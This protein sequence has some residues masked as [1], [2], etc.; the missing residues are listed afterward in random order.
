MSERYALLPGKDAIGAIN[1]RAQELYGV[2]ATATSIIDSMHSD[3]I[4][5]EMHRLI[6]M[7]RQFSGVTT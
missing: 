7:L 1:A 4:A 3:E 6:E 2:N 5:P